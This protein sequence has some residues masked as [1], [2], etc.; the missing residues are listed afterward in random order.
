MQ[1]LF[2]KKW[3]FFAVFFRFVGVDA[4]IDP[5]ECVN[6][7]G[8]RANVGIGPYKVFITLYKKWGFDPGNA[9]FLRLDIH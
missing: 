1:V 2:S 6:L 3:H 8:Y 7:G 5:S 4:H 9:A